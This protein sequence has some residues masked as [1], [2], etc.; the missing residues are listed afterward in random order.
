MLF[1]NSI[2]I[3][4]MRRVLITYLPCIN[5]KN[6]Y[7]RIHDRC[8]IKFSGPYF[9]RLFFF[10]NRSLYCLLSDSVKCIVE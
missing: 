4:V 9:A 6:L 8:V 10:C 3:S 1:V 7:H 5:V 2:L